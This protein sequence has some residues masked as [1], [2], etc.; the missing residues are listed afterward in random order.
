MDDFAVACADKETAEKVIKAIDEKMTIQIK[1]LGLLTRFN[2][3][4][5]LQAKQYIKLFNKTYIEKISS[6]HH[7]LAEEH[8]PMHEFPIPMNAEN[9][10][11]REL[12]FPKKN[13]NI[14]KKVLDSDIDKRLEN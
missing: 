10:Y 12:R 4:D 7:W 5:I 8:T 2:G 6:H 3:I 1:N 14:T 9:D 11:K 13:L